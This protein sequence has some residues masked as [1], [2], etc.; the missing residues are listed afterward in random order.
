MAG[1]PHRPAGA[2]T[3]RDG[4]GCAAVAD[5]IFADFRL[6]PGGAR[7]AERRCLCGGVDCA[8]GGAGHDL[9]ALSGAEPVCRLGAG[10]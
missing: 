5:H 10:Y 9:C 6:C 2:G 8:A 1:E 7:R 3:T 4:R